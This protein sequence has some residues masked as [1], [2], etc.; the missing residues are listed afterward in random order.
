MKKHS[1]AVVLGLL[2]GMLLVQSVG[3]AIQMPPVKGWPFDYPLQERYVDRTFYDPNHP[4]WVI[5]Q[6]FRD[7]VTFSDW[8]EVVRRTTGPE[9][10]LVGYKS[11]SASA[12]VIWI[13]STNTVYYECYLGY[14]PEDAHV[15]NGVINPEPAERAPAC[16]NAAQE[17]PN[18][19]AP[20]NWGGIDRPILEEYVD[21]TYF[22]PEHPHWIFKVVWR[23]GREEFWD[24]GEVIRRPTGH[25]AS[26]WYHPGERVVGSLL[27]LNGVEGTF[28]NCYIS[29]APGHG[30]VAYGVVNPWP[31][32]RNIT[33]CDLS[34]PRV[35]TGEGATR[36]FPPGSAVAGAVIKLDQPDGRTAYGCSIDWTSVG[37]TVTSGVLNPQPGEKP[38]PCF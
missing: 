15:F 23:D 13:P 21:Y 6:V 17:T 12:S 38:R 9:A 37:V 31:G 2:L 4:H 33:H 8:G 7:H 3:A 36:W 25:D 26:L 30:L 10:T 35:E 16:G 19:P 24:F 28:H 20:W 18:I 32:E 14:L 1:F 27:T 11:E 5:K 29:Y 34:K 22:D